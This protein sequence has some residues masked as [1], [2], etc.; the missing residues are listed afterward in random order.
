MKEML[1]ILGNLSEFFGNN[2]VIWIPALWLGFAFVVTW[3]LFSAKQH[4]PITHREA[5][6][7]WQVHKQK[8]QCGAEEWESLERRRKIIGFK[9]A[10]GHKHVQERPVV[11]YDV[12]KRKRS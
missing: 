6:M 12:E 2:L 11:R 5:E 4:A 1:E 9:C 7:L 8:A 10:C 3:Y